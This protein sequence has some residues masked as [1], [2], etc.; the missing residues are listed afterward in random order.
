M[1][2]IDGACLGGGNGLG[3]V[4]AADWKSGVRKVKDHVS[5]R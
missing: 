3:H 4:V 5:I 2:L 1:Y